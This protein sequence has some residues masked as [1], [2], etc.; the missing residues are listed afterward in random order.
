MRRARP[1]AE[2]LGVRIDLT[3][4]DAAAERILDWARVDGGDGGL[5]RARL[6]MTPNPEI[7]VVAAGDPDLR[8]IL[9]QADLSVPD[10]VGVVWALRRQGHEVAGGRVPGCDLLTEVLSR[11][12][13]TGLRAYLLGGRPGVAE[14]AGRECL[15]R[16][17]GLEIAGSHHG[18]FPPEED[19]AIARRVAESGA[20]LVAVGMGSPRQ[21]R[22]AWSQASCLPGTVIMPV[23]GSLDVLAGAVR[24][25]PAWMARHN[26]EWVGRIASEPARWRRAPR[27]IRFVTLVLRSERGRR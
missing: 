27:L 12:A 3:S 14:A 19:Q 1:S 5:E 18:Y 24:R 23:G 7:L 11:G 9:N 4:L 10:G 16:F 22:W 20:R 21:E 17:P 15:E 13:A 8:G 2:V 26:L 6:V 25:P